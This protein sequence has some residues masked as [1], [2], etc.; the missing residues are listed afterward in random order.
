MTHPLAIFIL[1]VCLASFLYWILVRQGIA[2]GV[3]AGLLRDRAKRD[4]NEQRAERE[5]SQRDGKAA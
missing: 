3:K 5:K 2:K 4:E 1:A